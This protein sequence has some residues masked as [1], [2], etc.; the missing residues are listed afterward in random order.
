MSFAVVAALAVAL[1]I[2]APL[3]AHLL[4]RGQTREQEFPPAGLVPITPTAARQR[5]R[6]ED[7]LL[8]SVR[9]AMVLSLAILGAT[10][11]VRCQR[12]SLSRA[13]GASVAFALV[14]DDSL[15]MR[16][17]IDGTPRW[18]RALAGA[19]QLLASAREGDAVA[20]VLSGAPARMTLAATTDLSA[21][22]DALDSLK[23]S[24][25]ATD[26]GAAVQMARAALRPLAHVDKRVILLSDLA[27]SVEVGGD[28]A[29]WTPLRDIAVPADDCGIVRAERDGSHVSAN[30]AC[31][32]AEAASARS[33]EIVVAAAN[34][35][36]GPPVGPLPKDAEPGRVVGKTTIS[37]RRGEQ[38]VVVTVD[39]KKDLP[40]DARLSPADALEED[41]LAPVA[42]QATTPVVGVVADPSVASAQTGG[43]TV[44]EQALAALPEPPIVRPLP[45]VPEDVKEY[46]ALAAIFVDDPPGL[47]PEARAAMASYVEQGGISVALLGSRA[48][49]AQLSAT[50]QPFAEGAVRW[51]EKPGLGI[52]AS[53]LSWLGPEAASLDDLTRT[54]RARLDGGLPDGAKIIGR[55]QDGRPWLLERRMKRGDVLTAGLPAS[56]DASDFA[57][58]PAFLA[59]LEYVVADARRRQGPGETI[60]GQQWLLEGIENVTVRGPTGAVSALRNRDSDGFTVTPEVRGRYLVQRDGDRRQNIAVLTAAEILEAPAA[61]SK[62]QT[63]GFG[64]AES[65]QVDASRELALIVL[66]LF[67]VELA[68]RAVRRRPRRSRDAPPKSLRAAAE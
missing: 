56:I 23:I 64:A 19:R 20:I 17:R 65:S 10:P 68:L 44:L 45:L 16:A 61:L 4:R 36:A 29:L 50:L 28:I 32:S 53:S 51:E 59:L 21:A 66:S 67:A 9:A 47:S 24:D 42:R 14:I 31:S 3:V 22:K 60:V 30:I 54:G 58:R 34:S 35:K 18:D 5:S 40:L 49:T 43:P 62:S 46:G 41:D 6:L 2:V 13:S 63:G 37:S 1:L 52:D 11:L 7:R 57:L 8:L 12:L 48:A 33:L 38:A 25:R 39:D 15:S 27:G 55:W 26:L